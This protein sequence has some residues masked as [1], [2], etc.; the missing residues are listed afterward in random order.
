M[1]QNTNE[2]QLYRLFFNKRIGG[3]IYISEKVLNNFNKF[4]E[5]LEP[6]D[7]KT[8]VRH[9]S[10]FHCYEDLLEGLKTALTAISNFNEDDVVSKTNET[11]TE[12]ETKELPSKD[13]KTSNRKRK[14]VSN[15]SNQDTDAVSDDSNEPF[16]STSILDS[17]E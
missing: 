7:N 15:D 11:I 10:K 12:Q 5:Y 2:P 6:V 16:T 8:Y 13:K 1:S 9:N 4:P 3:Q 14:T 17:N